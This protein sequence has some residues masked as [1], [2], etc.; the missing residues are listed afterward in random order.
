MTGVIVG[1]GEG[2][3][4]IEGIGAL[5][6]AALRAKVRELS[7]AIPALH[8]SLAFARRELRRRQRKAVRR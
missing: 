1:T 6:D 4:A 7:H 2:R 8:A 5:D 3:K